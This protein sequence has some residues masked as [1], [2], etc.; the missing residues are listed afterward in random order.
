MTVVTK[1]SKCK[2]GARPKTHLAQQL[3]QLLVVAHGEL[4]VARHDATLLVV[5]RGVAGELK[6]LG[7]KVL[8]REKGGAAARGPGGQLSIIPREP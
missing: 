8:L 7:G 4:D 2:R 6:H 3:G 5:P 1:I